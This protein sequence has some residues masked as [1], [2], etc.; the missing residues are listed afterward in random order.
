MCYLLLITLITFLPIYESHLQEQRWVCCHKDITKSY[1]IES[2]TQLC[3][4][5]CVCVSGGKKCLF[6]GNFGMLS[7]LETPVLRLALLPY[8]RR[9]RNV[10]VEFPSHRGREVILTLIPFYSNAISSTSSLKSA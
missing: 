7:F 5:T 6:F 4:D 9:Y 1:P 10:N 8:Y 3:L 2:F